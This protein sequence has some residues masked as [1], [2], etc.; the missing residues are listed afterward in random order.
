MAIVC[1]NDQATGSFARM[2]SQ[3]SRSLGARM[4]QPPPTPIIDLD[5]QTQ[6]FN[7]FDEVGQS[8]SPIND[9]P[10]S[11]TS[12]PKE[13]KKRA[14]R[15]KADEEIMRDVKFELGRIANALEA[16]KSKFISKDLFDEIMTLSD[17]YTEHDLGRAYDYLLQNLPLANGFMNK[18]HSFRCIWM[19][20]FLDQARASRRA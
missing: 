2:G 15:A 18:T 10:T 7:D 11:S 8:Q 1:G 3:S 13:G 9:A 12:K 6:G 19:D 20:D 14:K 16:D 17:R 5:N 4:E